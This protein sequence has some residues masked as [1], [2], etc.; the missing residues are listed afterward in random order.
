MQMLQ[1]TGHWGRFF[2]HTLHLKVQ[3]TH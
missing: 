2:F 1:K 3:Q